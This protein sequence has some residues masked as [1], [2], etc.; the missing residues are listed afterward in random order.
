MKSTITIF[1][2]VVGGQSQGFVVGSWLLLSC[3]V[4]MSQNTCVLIVWTRFCHQRSHFYSYRY[5]CPETKFRLT[6]STYNVVRAL[7]WGG[8]ARQKSCR[9]IQ[10]KMHRFLRSDGQGVS[11]PCMGECLVAIFPSIRSWGEGNQQARS[12]SVTLHSTLCLQSKPKHVVTIHSNINR[13]MAA[14]NSRLPEAKT[15]LERSREQQLG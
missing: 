13:G 8:V 1:F 4:G 3:W 5:R 9:T 10:L 14:V 2:E 7:G 12:V 6:Q 15:R 11:V